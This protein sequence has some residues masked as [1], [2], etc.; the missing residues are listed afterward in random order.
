MI[1]LI[2]I[3]K[4]ILEVKQFIVD[5][6]DVDFG[7]YDVEVAIDAL[8]DCVVEAVELLEKVE[9]LAHPVQTRVV[10]DAQTKQLLTSTVSAELAP[11][12]VKLALKFQ[13]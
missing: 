3:I 6:L 8:H 1:L 10:G 2:V 5:L 7:P 4:P 9:L 11:K 13:N 12:V